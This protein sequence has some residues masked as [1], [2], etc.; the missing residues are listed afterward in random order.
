MLIRWGI[1][2]ICWN[3]WI[4]I[5]VWKRVEATILVIFIGHIMVIELLQ[6]VVKMNLLQ[7]SADRQSKSA[8]PKYQQITIWVIFRYLEWI[9]FV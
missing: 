4:N 7:G 8:E 5:W 1:L 2:W 3:Q 9:L 6:F